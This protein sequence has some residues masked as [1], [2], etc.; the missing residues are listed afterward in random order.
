MSDPSRPPSLLVL[1]R[2]T[3]QAM[4]DELVKRVANAGFPNQGSFGYVLENIDPAGTRL[5]TLAA[6]AGLTHQSMGELVD[7][8]TAHGYVERIP[9]PTDRRAR[10]VRLTDHGRAMV[11]ATLKAIHA[12]ESDWQTHWKR[13]GLTDDLAPILAEALRANGSSSPQGV[14]DAS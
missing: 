3:T 8:L 5:T 9:D 2:R 11:R 12:I 4:V 6:R 10:L 13:A 7:K 14:P 1:L